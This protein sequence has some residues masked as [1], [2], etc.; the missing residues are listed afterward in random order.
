MQQIHLELNAIDHVNATMEELVMLL[1]DV[2][3]HQNILDMTVQQVNILEYT[4]CTI[5]KYTRMYW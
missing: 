2:Y 4:V 3:V 5:G 1:L